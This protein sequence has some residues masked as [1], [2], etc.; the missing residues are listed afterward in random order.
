MRSAGLKYAD[1]GSVAWDKIWGSFCDLAM[2]GGPPH[3]GSLLEPGSRA[4]ID[5]GPDRYRAVVDE[6]CRGV[7]LATQM[8]ADPASDRGWIRVACYG[9]AMAGWLVR[10]ITM[11]NVA[12]RASG[13]SVDLPASPAFRLDKEIKNVVT[14][15]AKTSHYWLGHMPRWQQRA[16]ATLFKTLDAEMPLIAPAVAPS[17][18]HVGDGRSPAAALGDRVREGTG[19]RTS[20][21]RYAGWLGL[22]CTSVRAAIWMMRALVVTNVLARREGI[23]LFVPVNASQDA[24]GTRVADVVTRVY[25]LA[26]ARG[27]LA[28]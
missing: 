16:I 14:V 18:P 1:D 27:V 17:E 24:D 28:D 7:S 25:R 8:P 26:G 12:V 13:E 10:A 23:T 2:A 11:E 21:H 4:D 6:I 20:H 15:I 22:D 9:E 19:L 3:K 5:A